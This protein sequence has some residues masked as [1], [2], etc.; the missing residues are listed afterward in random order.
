MTDAAAG[1]ADAVTD[2]A[3]GAVDAVT[4]AATDAAAAVGDAASTAGAAVGD[5]AT[6]VWDATKLSAEDITARIAAAPVSQSVKDTLTAT[7]NSVKD[8]PTAVQGVLDQ[9]KQ[10]MGL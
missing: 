5:A 7:Y 9:L 6:W 8:S 1:A 4:G 2:A 3:T 10:A